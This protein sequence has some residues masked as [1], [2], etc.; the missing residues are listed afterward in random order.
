MSR[1]LI[2]C[3]DGTWNTAS[4]SG[5]EQSFSTNVAKLA[6]AIKPVTAAGMSQVTFYRE[7]VGTQW[8]PDRL[9]GGAFGLGISKNICDCYHFLVNN[10]AAGDEIFLFGFSRGAYTVRSLA[11]LIRNCG[12][13]Q[14]EQAERIPEAYRLYRNRSDTA[15]PN[16]DEARLFRALY[17]REARIKCLGVWDTVGALGVPVTLLN[18]LFLRAY[19]FHNVRLSSSVDNAFHAIAIDERRKAFAPTL[20]E[21]QGVPGQT[22]EQVWFPGV[23]ANIGG[24]YSDSHLSDNALLW[25]IERAESCGLEIDPHYVAQALAP[26]Y[27][28]QLFDSLSLWY[29]PFG[30]FIR[31][32]GRACRDKQGRPIDTR[33]TV[34]P[35]AYERLEKLITPPAGP[36]QPRN[37]LEYIK[38]QGAGAVK[39]RS[40][41]PPSHTS[42]VSSAS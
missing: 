30:T 38:G 3:A 28:G 10:Y 6:R 29:R 34:H 32:I 9:L 39:D 40:I 12:I 23:H 19:E 26:T 16:G 22:V 25:M 33:E 24:G 13:L 20:W 8:G 41:Q 21:P 2:I 11:G 7:G 42:S 18:H 5:R 37:L 14:P 27:D 31:K 1:R 35:S 15:H 17:A 4:R 36:Y